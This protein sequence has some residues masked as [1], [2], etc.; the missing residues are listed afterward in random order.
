MTH[1][2]RWRSIARLRGMSV[3]QA[4]GVSA[5]VGNNFLRRL[6]VE[7]ETRGF[8]SAFHKALETPTDAR[9]RFAWLPMTV[10]SVDGPR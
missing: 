10:W 7:I 3:R 2:T 4:R 1:H 5:Y 8:Y 9:A 6:M